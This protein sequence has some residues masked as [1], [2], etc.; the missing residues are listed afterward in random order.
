MLESKKDQLQC[1][2]CVLVIYL[3]YNS[4][5][6][7]A[8]L[9]NKSLLELRERSGSVVECLTPDQEAAGSNLHGI[10]ALWSLSKTHILA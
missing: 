3:L 5:P 6:N 8:L 9:L 7:S 2:N 4:P 10:S 1:V